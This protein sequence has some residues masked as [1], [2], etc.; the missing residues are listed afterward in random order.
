MR[1]AIAQA[2]R[3]E[4]INVDPFF[5]LMDPVKRPTAIEQLSRQSQ[6]QPDPVAGSVSAAAEQQA[7]RATREDADFINAQEDFEAELNILNA[8]ADSADNAKLKEEL[9]TIRQEAND[10]SLQKVSR[11]LLAA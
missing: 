4:D 7:K 6:P 10:T 5:D 2:K 8:L 9:K 3:G 11:P 1:A